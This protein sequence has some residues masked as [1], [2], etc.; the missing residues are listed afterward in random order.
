MSKKCKSL[1][2]MKTKVP[3]VGFYVDWVLGS[4]NGMVCSD[5]STSLTVKTRRDE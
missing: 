1:P 3:Q 4:A 2:L 5:F